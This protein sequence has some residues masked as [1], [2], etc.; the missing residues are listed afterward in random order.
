[1][2]A[3]LPHTQLDPRPKE[4]GLLRGSLALATGNAYGTLFIFVFRETLRADKYVGGRRE[5]LNRVLAAT[6]A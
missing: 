3:T 2:A 1:M 4:T 6:R 5:G